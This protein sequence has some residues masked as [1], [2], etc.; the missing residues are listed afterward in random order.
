MLNGVVTHGVYDA[1]RMYTVL[2]VDDE[3]DVHDLLLKN[4]DKKKVR[5]VSAFDGEEG[6]KKIEEEKPDLVLLDVM[7]PHL[8]GR[9]VM[10]RIGAHKEKTGMIVVFFTA[11]EE[12]SD[13]IAGLELGADDYVTKP[14]PMSLLA[15]KLERLLD[16][17]AKKAKKE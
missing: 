13:R 10:K 9:D 17:R 6:L 3:A 7:M 14:M 1:S 4:V 16:A 11:R 15:R 5:L 8:D 12:Q 2:V